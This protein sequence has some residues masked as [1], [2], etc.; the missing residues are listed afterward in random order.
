MKKRFKYKEQRA[1]SQRLFMMAHSGFYVSV[2]ILRLKK[3]MI[4]VTAEDSKGLLMRSRTKHIENN[5]KCSRCFFRKLARHRNTM[6]S[7][8]NEDGKEQTETKDIL[9]LI[10]T[11]Y[12]ELYKEEVTD[13]RLGKPIEILKPNVGIASEL[14]SDL[15][16]NELTKAIQSMQD[17]KP[18]GADGLPK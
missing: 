4:A 17:Y 3:E 13:N 10:H 6:L 5:K 15:N 14:E 1:K 18:P 8:P 11:F 7:I 9:D 12:T 16:V 2:E